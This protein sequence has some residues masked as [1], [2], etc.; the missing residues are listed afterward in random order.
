MGTPLV[1]RL[2]SGLRGWLPLIGL[3]ALV[4]LFTPWHW[5]AWAFMW[6]LAGAIYLGC[7]W[8]TWRRANVAGVPWWRHAGYLIAWP[9]L[10]AASFL[11]RPSTAPPAT[12]E[13]VFAAIKS[14]LGIALFFAGGALVSRD[15][16]YL[17]GWIGMVGIVLTLHFGLFHLLSCAWRRLGVDAPPLMDRP[18][19]CES[20]SEFWGRRWNRAFRDLTHGFLFRPLTP[21]LGVRGALFSGFVF[22]GVVHDI[23]ISLPARGGYGGPTMFFVCQ[24]VAMLVERSAS[25]QRAGLG[26]GAAGRVFTAIVLLLPLSCLFHPPFVERIV[27]P[28]M[29]A[30]GAA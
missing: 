29:R 10:D 28:F 21:W 15:R 7:R 18:L 25:G 24:A 1:R 3:P 19:A 16:P 26:R 22:S 6:A 2:R 23:V 17:A 14:G 30:M 8:L 5:P 20:V 11:T 4:V 13:W 12:R 27:V 9:G